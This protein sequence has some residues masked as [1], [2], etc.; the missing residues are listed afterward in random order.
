MADESSLEESESKRHRD[1]LI[2]DK[3]ACY[4]R[5]C[6]SL[7]S[8]RWPTWI[9]WAMLRP[10]AHPQ[11]LCGRQMPL[12]PCSLQS[13]GGWLHLEVGATFSLDVKMCPLPTSSLPF[14]GACRCLTG[15]NC[16]VCLCVASWVPLQEASGGRC[17][18]TVRCPHWFPSQ[19]RTQWQEKAAGWGMRGAG[20]LVL[21]LV[22]EPKVPLSCV[23]WHLSVI[24]AG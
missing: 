4:A 23:W 14:S 11:S 18:P 19:S 17:V 3:V 1:K 16:H 22:P 6:H 12:L 10:S 8:S 2:P 21:L 20:W 15:S 9:L 13:Q 5:S 24:S 7:R